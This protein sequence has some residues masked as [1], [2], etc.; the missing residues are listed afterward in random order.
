VIFRKDG[1]EARRVNTH[2]YDG[3]C[4]LVAWCGGRAID[5]GDY[6]IAL[7]TPIGEATV[8]HHDWVIRDVAGT[9]HVYRCPE[10]RPIADPWP[11]F[12]TQTE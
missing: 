6:V 10:W 3:L 5:D 7:S 12:L 2:D 8:R 4:Q 1:H 9:F 11:W